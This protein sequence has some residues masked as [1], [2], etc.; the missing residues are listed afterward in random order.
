MGT[1]HLRGV[2]FL[3]SVRLGGLVGVQGRRWMKHWGFAWV[4]SSRKLRKITG[5]FW[6]QQW[7]GKWHSKFPD[8]VLPQ[9]FPASTFELSRVISAVRVFGR[10]ELRGC[11]NAS[12]NMCSPLDLEGVGEEMINGLL[13]WL[14]LPPLFCACF[15]TL[16]LSAT[17]LQSHPMTRGALGQRKKSAWK[18]GM[19]WGEEK[20]EHK[21]GFWQLVSKSCYKNFLFQQV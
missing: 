19:H 7:W 12:L 6:V 11:L 20:L 4:W 8:M 16:R 5:R 15:H 17:Q 2:G 10:P 9:W 18:I 3:S 13:L 21:E 14:V 1:P